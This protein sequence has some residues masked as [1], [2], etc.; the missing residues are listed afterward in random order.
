MT[1]KVAIVTDTTACI[2]REHAEKYAIE[3]V[4][5]VFI[6][7]DESYRDGI[8]MS[9]TEFYARLRRAEKLPTTSST[10]PDPYLEA[11]RRAS[12]IASGILCITPPSK[13]SGMFDSAQLAVKMANEALPNAVI[14]V[15]NCSTAAAGQGL[16]VLAAARAAASGKSLT[17]VVEVARSVMRRVDLL[18]TLD[19]MKYLVK[20]V[21]CRKQPPL[22]VRCFKLSLFLP[23]AMAMLT[24]S[25][26]PELILAQQNVSWR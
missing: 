3:L 20:G 25:Q 15:L 13:L 23:L 21:V 22:L 5:V 11:Y 12:Q 19:T 4:P 6:F 18:A 8:D 9:P 10:P 7:D 14:E 24:Q 1:N 26:M 17:E 16:I 2:P